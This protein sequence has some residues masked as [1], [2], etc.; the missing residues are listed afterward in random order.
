MRRSID[1]RAV[2][3]A[4]I[5]VACWSVP[6]SAAD[7]P[8]KAP[9]YAPASA[10]NWTGFYLGGHVG[11]G[12]MHKE[13]NI[14]DFGGFPG[15]RIGAGDASGFLGGAQVGVNYQLDAVVVGI[16]AD[17]SWADLS[18]PTCNFSAPNTAPLQCQSKADRFGT[19]TARLGVA[20]DRALIYFKGG[21]AWVHEEHELLFFVNPLLAPTAVVSKS[22]WG[23]TAGA[24][25]EYALARNWSAKLEYDFMGFGTSRYLFDF[26][27]LNT[28][29][30][31]EIKQRVHAVKF[32]WNYK[33]DW[34]GPVV[35]NY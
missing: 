33:F 21:A 16:E 26:P 18:G 5:A 29:L 2:A 3:S 34:G 22:K 8:V 10:Y 17:F 4:T 6:A 9:T 35:A 13:W 19:V 28:A 11:G 31:I 12:W 23:W 20:F 15:F 14:V 30:G 24:G 7:L 32:G 25:I 27:T 1:L